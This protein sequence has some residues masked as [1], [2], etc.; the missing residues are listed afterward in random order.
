MHQAAYRIAVPLA[1]T[2]SVGALVCCQQILGLDEGKLGAVVQRPAAG[3]RASTSASSTGGTAATTGSTSGTT[4]GPATSSSSATATSSSGGSSTSSS[5]STGTGGADCVG[6]VTVAAADLI[7][8]M[9]EG[10]GS[11][12]KQGGRSGSWFTYN[13]GTD[14]GVQTP[15]AGGPCLPVAIPGGRCGSEHAMNTFGSGFT[16]YGI[17]IGFDLNHP[18]GVRMPYDVSAHTGIAFWARGPQTVQVQILEQ[19]TTPTDQGGTCTATC[20]DHYFIGVPVPAGWQQIPVPFASLKQTG[21][22]TVVAWDPKTV[23]AEQ[24]AVY[25]APTFDFWIDDIGFY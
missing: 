7:D 11:I 20:S 15:M 18:S 22:G 23:L 14:G 9:E 17:G 4:G 5:T 19:G 2:V 25:P 13:D 21:W 12:I 3:A 16:N 8:D 6:T 1:A 10:S 24:L